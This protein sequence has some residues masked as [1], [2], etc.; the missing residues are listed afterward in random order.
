[1]SRRTHYHVHEDYGLKQVPST[2]GLYIHCIRDEKWSVIP[3]EPLSCHG[4]VTCSVKML[5]ADDRFGVFHS[6]TIA[7]SELKATKENWILKANLEAFE[8]EMKIFE[9]EFEKVII[10]DLM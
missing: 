1:M 9:K 7:K 10:R 6:T 2:D 8:G 5:R 4:L 3:D